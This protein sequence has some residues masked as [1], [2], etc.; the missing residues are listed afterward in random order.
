MEKLITNLESKISGI[1]YPIYW[2]P[3]EKTVWRA[4]SNE[5]KEMIGYN[6]NDELNAITTARDF[7][8]IQI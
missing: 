4:I 2:N 7:L 5:W 8:D 3:E 1:S 6:A